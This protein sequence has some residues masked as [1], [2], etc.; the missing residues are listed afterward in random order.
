MIPR[1][2]VRETESRVGFNLANI[3]PEEAK[4]QGSDT[5]DAK[6]KYIFHRQFLHSLSLF[7]IE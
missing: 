7:K 1:E 5:I 6:K 2:K 3:L 4:K